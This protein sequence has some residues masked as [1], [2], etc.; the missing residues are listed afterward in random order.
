MTD[1]GGIGAG[2]GTGVRSSFFISSSPISD[3]NVFLNSVDTCMVGSA[4]GEAQ[5]PHQ[6]KRAHLTFIAVLLTATLRLQSCGQVLKQLSFGLPYRLQEARVEAEGCNRL[7]ARGDVSRH[8]R[9]AGCKCRKP[10]LLR[11]VKASSRG[12]GICAR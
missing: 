9:V 3:S 11:M 7:A 2:L 10:K 4:S 6:P 1:T 5:R 8:E 12:V